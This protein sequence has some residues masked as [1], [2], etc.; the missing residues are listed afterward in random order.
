[1][2]TIFI[3]QYCLASLDQETEYFYGTHRLC[4]NMIFGE[5]IFHLWDFANYLRFEAIFLSNDYLHDFQ[6]NKI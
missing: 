2:W 6:V 5:L 4:S 3:F 1:L